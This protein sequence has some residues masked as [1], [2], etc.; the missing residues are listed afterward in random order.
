MNSELIPFAADTPAYKATKNETDGTWS[1]ADVPVFELGDHKGETYDAAWAKKTLANFK[2][3]ATKGFLPPV[4]IG[5]KQP[6]GPELPAVGLVE[7]LKIVGNTLFASMKN[8]TETVMNDIKQGSWPYRSPTVSAEKGVFASLSLLG[9][10][11]PYFKFAPLAVEFCAQFAEEFGM[12]GDLNQGPLYGSKTTI[13]EALAIREVERAIDEKVDKLR[14]SWWMFQDLMRATMAE[15]SLTSEAKASRVQAL[16]TEFQAIIEQSKPTLT[17]VMSAEQK[18][19]EMGDTIITDRFS[20]EDRAFIASFVE[21]AVA[22]KTAAFQAELEAVKTERDQA[23]AELLQKAK[24][25]TEVEEARRLEVVTRFSDE[26]VRGLLPGLTDEKHHFRHAVAPAIM[27]I[28]PLKE[29]A[30]KSNGATVQFSEGGNVV[31]KPVLEAVMQAFAETVKAAAAGTLLVRLGETPTEQ[32]QENQNLPPS[33]PEEKTDTGDAITA[34]IV[35]L[36]AAEGVQYSD[37]KK[38]YTQ[39]SAYRRKAMTELNLNTRE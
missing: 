37:L 32:F 26:A 18:E 13:G 21:D 25:I 14:E 22:T 19:N 12:V 23:N 38:N 4:T 39:F 27:G 29:L 31:E 11:T 8:I 7:N 10:E 30:I 33:G 16:I 36:A 28:W 2:A 15:K 34:K 1:I 20:A 5:H 24:S 17:A 6:G 35:A 3:F 9:G